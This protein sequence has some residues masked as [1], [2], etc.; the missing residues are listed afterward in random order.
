MKLERFK[1]ESFVIKIKDFEFNIE[2][3][4]IIKSFIY[5]GSLLSENVNKFFWLSFSRNQIIL[6]E[7]IKNKNPLK[8]GT[9]SQPPCD[10][11]LSPSVGTHTRKIIKF[12]L[13]YCM[14]QGI[15]DM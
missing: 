13:L 2:S 14:F 8:L 12:V 15:L 1:I 6:R 10:T 9:L 7:A 4:H 11:P 3:L 5:D